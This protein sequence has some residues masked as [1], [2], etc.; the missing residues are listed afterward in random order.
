MRLHDWSKIPD[1]LKDRPY[2]RH[3]PTHTHFRTTYDE[4]YQVGTYI[5]EHLNAG[6]GPRGCHIP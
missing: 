5:A 2:V 6:K 1:E 4:L 3:T